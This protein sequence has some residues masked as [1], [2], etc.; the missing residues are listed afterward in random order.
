MSGMKGPPAGP[1][2]LLSKKKTLYTQFIYGN[3]AGREREEKAA[4]ERKKGKWRDS[5]PG[6]N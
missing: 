6:E 4:R 3:S 2:H 5:G 1:P